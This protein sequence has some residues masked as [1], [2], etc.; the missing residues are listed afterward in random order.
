MAYVHLLV[1]HAL[2]SLQH[3]S[4]SR[5]SAFDADQRR[6]KVLDEF[7]DLVPFLGDKESTLRFTSMKEAWEDVWSR[8]G[9]RQSQEAKAEDVSATGMYSRNSVSSVNLVVHTC[10]A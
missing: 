10:S 4:S 1:I 8:I 7:L 5:L 9:S 6:T 3:I 2:P